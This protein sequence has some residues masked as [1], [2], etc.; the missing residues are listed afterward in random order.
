MNKSTHAAEAHPPLAVVPPP[1]AAARD[2]AAVQDLSTHSMVELLL[3]RLRFYVDLLG[4]GYR[5]ALSP[6]PLPRSLRAERIAL[7]IDLPELDAV[8]LWSTRR[9]DG[10]ICIPFVEFILGQIVDTMD[11]LLAEV[12]P[13]DPLS[14]N[15]IESA[16]EAVAGALET[17]GAGGKPGRLLPSLRDVFVPVSTLDAL[18]GPCGCLVTVV[19]RCEALLRGEKPVFEH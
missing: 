13:S 7:G 14:A 2:G 5:L 12:A 3:Q 15:E 6:D 8:P 19:R 9:E 16:R 17:M 18:C 4:A 1:G 10:T 11:S